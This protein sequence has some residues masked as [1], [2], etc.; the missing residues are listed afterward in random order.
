MMKKCIYVVLLL[1]A[2]NGF[3]QS[4]FDN[5][6]FLPSIKSVEFYNTAKVASFPAIVLNSNEQVLLGFDDLR[7]GT[8]NYYYTLQH[9]DSKWNASNIS[10]AEYL[11]SYNDDQ[12]IDYAYSNV[13]KQKYTH[14]EI[15]LPNNNIAPKIA[16]NY[17]LKVY[18]DRDQA[19]TILT[20]RLYVVGAKGSLGA[21]IAP[22]NNPLYRQ[23]NQKINFELNLGNLQ[24]QNPNNDIKV[25]VMQNGRSETGQWTTQAYSIR[26]NQLIYN[27]VYS[28]DFAGRNEFR[29]F[30]TR[31]LKLKSERIG[32]LYRDT[33]Y[34]AVLLGDPNRNLPNYSF[35][36]DND[37]NFFILNQD[38]SDARRDGDYVHVYFSLA[39]NKTPADGTP[40]IVGRF[41][42]FKIDG[43]SKLEYEPIKGRFYTDLF[44][45]QGVYDYQYVWVDK[46]SK[47]DDIALEGNYFE[48]ENE[49]QV[50]VYYRPA[51]ARWEELIGYRLLS[52]KK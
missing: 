46:N 9:C 36:F 1:V 18:E 51:N 48:T 14:Y 29:R 38:G 6:V 2:S 19:K 27:D 21:S 24:V 25:L 33:S 39:A 20:R 49:Y 47:P 28:N 8:R 17:I 52:N 50:L 10:S 4:V 42:D 23:T 43:R 32:A 30:D 44:L 41:N 22:T 13:T 16:G 5:N 35:Q 12:I 37:G 7:G 26:G 31:T 3:A 34:T 45:K 15:K 11:K 40:Y